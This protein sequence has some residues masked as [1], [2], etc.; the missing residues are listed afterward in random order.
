MIESAFRRFLA[1]RLADKK[2][3]AKKIEA[4]L[5]ARKQKRVRAAKKIQIFVRKQQLRA[6]L[7][8]WA[9]ILS[10]DKPNTDE[11]TRALLLQDEADA[12]AQADKIMRALVL[13]DTR[14]SLSPPAEKTKEDEGGY[15]VLSIL[16]ML[17]L[18]TNLSS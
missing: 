18:F 15:H 4:C 2:I 7:L 12:E 6:N 10:R 1:R 5:L 17:S 14:L 11:Q 13:A 9:E 3:A 16:D 8:A